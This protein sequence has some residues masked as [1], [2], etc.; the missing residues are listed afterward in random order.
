MGLSG[1]ILARE[2]LITLTRVA[3]IDLCPLRNPPQLKFLVDAQSSRCVSLFRRCIWNDEHKPA[4]ADRQR[5]VRLME[6]DG[7]AS[8]VTLVWQM[9]E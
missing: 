7:F 5:A 3:N 9:R 1:I 4:L 6:S 8:G 2:P